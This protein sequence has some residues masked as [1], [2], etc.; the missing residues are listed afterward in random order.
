MGDEDFSF[1]IPGT[2]AGMARDWSIL[3]ANFKSE[4]GGGGNWNAFALSQQDP[5]RKTRGICSTA[6]ILQMELEKRVPFPSTE[7]LGVLVN[8]FW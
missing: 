5:R 7:G 6:T 1:K 8:T 3:F 4:M 2:Y